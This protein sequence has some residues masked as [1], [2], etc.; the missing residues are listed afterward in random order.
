MGGGGIG[1]L[2][3]WEVGVG[4]GWGWGKEP[5]TVGPP[6]HPLSWVPSAWSGCHLCVISDRSSSRA[7]SM[8]D[9]T[10]CFQSDW[11]HLHPHFPDEQ[12]QSVGGEVPQARST[13]SRAKE[14]NQKLS[15]T[16]PSENLL[17]NNRP[18]Q[19]ILTPQSTGLAATEQRI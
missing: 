4:W 16:S 6:Q 12:T 11:F 1:R 2:G 14:R 5:F 18:A 13:E 8:P 10:G 9:P 17:T 3:D 7:A 19:E 15:D